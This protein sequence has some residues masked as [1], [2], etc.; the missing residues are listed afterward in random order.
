[1]DDAQV[2]APTLLEYWAARRVLPGRRVVR[3]GVRLAR[4]AGAPAGSIVVVCGLAGAL[5]SDVPPGTILVPE[6]VGL[7]DG[8]MMHC[9]PI[10]VDALVAAARESGQQPDTRPLLTAGTLVVG[11]ERRTWAERGFMAADMETG[12]LADR[13][14]RVATVRVV[15]DSPERGIS[16]EWLRPGL[17]LLRPQLWDELFWLCHAAPA[18]ALL[19][20]RVLR[21]GLNRL[22]GQQV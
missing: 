21:A 3:S 7:P 2:L 15:L 14:L 17:A 12:L 1:M 4:W 9:D 18:Y 20:A 11:A 13:H 16:Q 6:Q 22:A 5:A 8:R 19:A 10:L